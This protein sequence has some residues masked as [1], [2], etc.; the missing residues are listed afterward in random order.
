MIDD[1][2]YLFP[3][4][5]QSVLLPSTPRAVHLFFAHFSVAVSLAEFLPRRIDTAGE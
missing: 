3:R 4:V 1:L 5:S 2:S